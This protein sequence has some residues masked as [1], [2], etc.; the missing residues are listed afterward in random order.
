ML[1]QT[2]GIVFQSIRFKD[3]GL[4]CKIFTRE[5]GLLSFIFPGVLSMKKGGRIRPAHLIPLSPV[6]LHFY[7]HSN[8]SLKRVKE[9]RCQPVLHDMYVHPSKRAFSAFVLEVINRSVREEG[10]V[11]EE[12]FDFLERVIVECERDL[13]VEA[14]LS[15]RFIVELSD[16]TGHGIEANYS[17]LTPYFSRREG[18]FVRQ[19]DPDTG[20]NDEDSR[21][22]YFLLIGVRDMDKRFRLPF[23]NQLIDFAR[24]HYM[25]SSPLKSMDIFR[26]VNNR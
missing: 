22:F 17:E 1:V 9:L 25:G 3:S 11:M 14:W 26:E 8:R 13:E 15:H 12:V 2:K 23:L 18:G 4:I 20:M 5:Y 7:Y 6:D 16:L 19:Y 21:I 10:L 24:Y